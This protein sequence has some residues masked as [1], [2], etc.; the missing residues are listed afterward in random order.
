MGKTY[1]DDMLQV[2][3]KQFEILLQVAENQWLSGKGWISPFCKQFK[4]KEY[5][6]HGEAGSV[7]LGAVVIE[8]IHMQGLL[9]KY[10]PYDQLNFNELGMFWR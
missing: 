2:K 7:D 4:I 1:I 6:W 10:A 9:E 5:Q 3:R 8:R